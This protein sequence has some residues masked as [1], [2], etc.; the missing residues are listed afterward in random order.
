MKF[1]DNP[2][3]FRAVKANANCE[4]LCER[5]LLTGSA[6]GEFNAE[7]LV[8]SGEGSSTQGRAAGIGTSPLW[9]GRPK[10]KL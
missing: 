7:V 1:G 2:W 3:L 5:C 9:S 6:G 10:K 8:H 4:Y